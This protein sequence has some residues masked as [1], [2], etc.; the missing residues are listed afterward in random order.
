[1]SYKLHSII[2]PK[3]YY[4]YK[5]AEDWIIKHNYKTNKQRETPN[6]WRFSQLTPAYLTK[7]KMDNYRTKILPNHIMLVIGYAR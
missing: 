3:E 5:E 2:I 7:I 4:T 1:M 6:E